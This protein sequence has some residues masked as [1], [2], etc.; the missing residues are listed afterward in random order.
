[1]DVST[2]VDGILERKT[3]LGMTVQQISD[4]SGVPKSTVDN[5]L[6]KAVNNPSA[7]N[8]LDIASA[9]GYDIGGG[10][11]KELEAITDPC[12]RYIVASNKRHTDALV[13]QSNAHNKSLM[14]II[15]IL[16]IALIILLLM[17]LAVMGGIAWII[18]YD[19]TNLD[20]GWIQAINS[21]YHTAAVDALLSVVDWMGKIWA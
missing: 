9:V 7:Q 12:I 14:R 5:I 11:D 19:L 10:A 18:H 13:S 15:T 3:A 20:R 1:M 21:G 17:F 6:R 8:I 2:I 16:L 4:A